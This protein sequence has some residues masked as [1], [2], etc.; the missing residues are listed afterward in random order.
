MRDKTYHIYLDSPE[1]KLLIHS[2]V[3]LKN[4]LIQQGRY[5]DCVDELVFKVI[6]APTKRI[7]IEYV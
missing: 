4:Q 2:L 3:E 6:N 7:K 1:R 5:T